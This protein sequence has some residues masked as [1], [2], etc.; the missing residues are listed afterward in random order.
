[1]LHT[2]NTF[3]LPLCQGNVVDQF[4]CE[5][6]KILR[7]SCSE[8]EYL[9]QARIIDFSLFLIFGCF[10]FLV[11]SF[12]QIFRAVLKMPSEQGQHKA[13]STCLPHLA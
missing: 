3:S 8:S 7:L 5:I 11:L 2:V 4:F 12:V 10:V 1:L 9:R 13:F 6:A